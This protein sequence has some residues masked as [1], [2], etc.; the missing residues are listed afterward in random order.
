MF[1]R[2]EEH[3]ED[4]DKANEKNALVKHMA[5]HHPGQVPAFKFEMH[6][7]WKTSLSHQIGEAME[8]SRHDPTKLMNSKSEWGM[9]TIPRVKVLA[10]EEP[11]APQ[12]SPEPARSVAF[13]AYLTNPEEEPNQRP[14]KR[15]RGGHCVCPS[16]EHS[17]N[18]I[19][20]ATQSTSNGQE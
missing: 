2:I 9:N 14:A 8:I 16:P 12:H 1:D 5:N 15:K 10:P 6:K 7:V 3:L 13:Q 18:Q 17:R 20:L 4:L 11:S 19:L